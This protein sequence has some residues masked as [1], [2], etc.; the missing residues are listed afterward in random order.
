MDASP[1]TA[2]PAKMAKR[3]V[4]WAEVL[5]KEEDCSDEFIDLYSCREP[6]PPTGV[7][8]FFDLNDRGNKMPDRKVYKWL[9]S[10]QLVNNHL[11]FGHMSCVSWWSGHKA[12]K[13]VVAIKRLF[14]S[15]RTGVHA[16]HIQE[17]HINAM[18]GYLENVLHYNDKGV[19]MLGSL[20]FP[21]YEDYAFVQAPVL[22]GS[23]QKV[24]TRCFL[25]LCTFASPLF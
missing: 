3:S 21:G 16:F 9:D 20:S 18:L 25:S 4:S 24:C 7:A 6:D 13:E 23:L 12:R 8:S 15:R 1:D 10:A 17:D 11:K 14:F 2:R 19:L 5:G 22:N